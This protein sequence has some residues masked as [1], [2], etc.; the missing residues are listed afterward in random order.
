MIKN[1]KAQ[2]E[3]AQTMMILIVFFVLLIFSLV[4]FIQFKQRQSGVEQKA[5]ND[6]EMVE[7]AQEVYSLSELGCS[8]DNT[9]K[10]DCLDILKIEAFRDRLFNFGNDYLYYRKRL[11][12]IKIEVEEIYPRRSGVNFTKENAIFDAFPPNNQPSY[13]YAE[14]PIQIPVVLYNATDSTIGSYYFGVLTV[15]SYFRVFNR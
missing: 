11:G 15:T 7:K 2:M 12:N 6:Q 1:K 4:F 3:T 8:Y 5:Y 14:N 10:Y 13:R 9:L